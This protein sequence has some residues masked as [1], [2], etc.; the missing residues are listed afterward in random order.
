MILINQE[1]CKSFNKIFLENFAINQE[2]E[3]IAHSFR[4][5]GFGSV[6]IALGR[7]LSSIAGWELCVWF[8]KEKQLPKIRSSTLIAIGKLMNCSEMPLA[9]IQASKNLMTTSTLK[10]SVGWFD[11]VPNRKCLLNDIL[12][13]NLLCRDM[14][15]ALFHDGI[16][17]IVR[18][19]SMLS[20]GCENNRRDWKNCWKVL[21]WMTTEERSPVTKCRYFNSS[22]SKNKRVDSYS[23]ISLG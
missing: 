18:K 17:I 7:S 9:N 23:L 21:R 11:F 6:E 4:Y 1:K 3:L 19:S 13:R 12:F 14:K 10:I 15:M 16:S 20:I 22:I 2:K 5:K 8:C